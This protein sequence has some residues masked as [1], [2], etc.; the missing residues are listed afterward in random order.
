MA[1]REITVASTSDPQ[2]LVN[3]AAY[4]SD[5]DLRSGQLPD[6]EEPASDYTLG[7]LNQMQRDHAQRMSRA[8]EN[9]PDAEALL[10]AG[11]GE[12]VPLLAIVEN[13]NSAAIT[14]H[15]ATNQRDLRYLQE[16]QQTSPA[17]ARDWVAK[18]GDRLQ[19]ADLNYREFQQQRE[20]DE[21][22]RRLDR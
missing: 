20:K 1:D 3:Q 14:L 7:E 13:E 12:A 11:D 6:I 10:A 21:R 9:H 4:A 8:L 18:L 2:E 5:D 19:P 17:R 16:L 22:R 15:L